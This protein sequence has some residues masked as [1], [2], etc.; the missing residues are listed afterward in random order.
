MTTVKLNIPKY[1]RPK[2]IQEFLEN[3][4][5]LFNLKGKSVKKLIIT[6]NKIKDCSLIGILLIIKV[7]AYSVKMKIFEEAEIYTN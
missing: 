7:M 3:V 6:A 2:A 4:K 1:F 5:F